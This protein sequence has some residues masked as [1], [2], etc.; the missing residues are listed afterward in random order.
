MGIS[1]MN[2]TE[3]DNAL[4]IAVQQ[5]WIIINCMHDEKTWGTFANYKN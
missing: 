1:L 5:S 2:K 3:D 4:K